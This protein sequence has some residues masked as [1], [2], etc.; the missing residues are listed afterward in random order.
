MLRTE[1]NLQRPART[2]R[3]FW[4]KYGRVSAVGAPK[5][6][7][8]KAALIEAIKDGFWDVG[9][10]LPAEAELARVTPLSLGTVQ[11]A[12]RDLVGQGLVE[13]RPGAGTFVL[14]R[15]KP[16][17]APWHFR[18]HDDSRQEFFPVFLQVDHVRRD[19]V[20]G[21]WSSHLRWT[22]EVVEIGRLVR[23]GQ[24]FMIY[25]QFFI[26]AGT[27]DKVR[28]QRRT[29]LE[30]INLRRE[31]KLDITR[32]AYDLRMQLFPE[33][34]CRKIGVSDGTIGLVIDICASAR[35]PHQAYFQ[36]MFV[37][38]TMRWLRIGDFAANLDGGA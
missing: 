19:N 25:S 34:I 2:A 10:K 17:D 31:L 5:Y 38:P 30:G 7:H 15:P 13:R 26:A 11:A 20:P 6:A 35:M 36:R 21:P 1:R 4:R 3:A 27:Y 33:W 9:Q 8:L 37:P 32:M 18:F 14:H 29:P 12:F 22:D 28:G 24:E 23:I 16:L